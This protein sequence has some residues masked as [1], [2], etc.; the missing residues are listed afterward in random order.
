MENAEQPLDVAPHAMDAA[1]NGSSNSDQLHAVDAPAVP[2]QPAHTVARTDPEKYEVEEGQG[3][4][5]SC[6]SAEPMTT[7]G[8]EAA[9]APATTGACFS[10]KGVSEGVGPPPAATAPSSLHATSLEPLPGNNAPAAET[11][12][13]TTRNTDGSGNDLS[14]P[15]PTAT[16]PT[17]ASG[18]VPTE[19]RPPAIPNANG[20]HFNIAMNDDDEEFG[21]DDN[22]NDDDQ[23]R[24]TDEDIQRDASS[25]AV[26]AMVNVA[27]LF[28]AGLFVCAIAGSILFTGQ[29]GFV[30]LCIVICLVGIVVGT[31]AWITKIITGDKKLRPV[32]RKMRRWRAI[33]KAV[34]VNE[35]I[36]FRL[37]MQEHL[38]LTNGGECGD[39]EDDGYCYEEMDANDNNDGTSS[40]Q[41][42]STATNSSAPN[43]NNSKSRS[44]IFGL[45]VKPFVKGRKKMKRKL[46]RKKN[47]KVNTAAATNEAE[48]STYVPPA[49]GTEMV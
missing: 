27:L 21:S 3:T 18:S 38:L 41:Q 30:T 19:T 1:A 24:Y 2:A 36:N 9:A 8:G 32:Q 11:D 39:P 4:S 6:S 28:F 20:G 46:G 29:F 23:I 48:G 14:Q 44:V 35:M 25:I 34:V 42:T 10:A 5:T 16:P 12:T 43:A 45:M 37:D 13:A 17:A 22:D 26:M 7:D 15:L 49:V 31:V 40:G 33:A 47:D